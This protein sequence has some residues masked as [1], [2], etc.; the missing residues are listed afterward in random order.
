MYRIFFYVVCFTSLNAFSQDSILVIKDSIPSKILHQTTS[1]QDFFKKVRFAYYAE[2]HQFLDNRE[3]KYG[4]APSQTMLGGRLNAMV[5]A[6]IDSTMGLMAGINYLYEYGDR[7]DGNIP[8]VNLFYYF[9]IPKFTAV[10][11]SFPRRGLLNYPL[12]ILTDS[13]DNYR[14]NID[15]GYFEVRGKWGFQNLWVDWTGRQRS[16]V[17]ESFLAGFSGRV[18]MLKESL[19][20][21]DHYFAMYHNANTSLLDNPV[22]DNGGYSIML[23]TDLTKFTPL[24]LFSFR[25]GILGSYD[26]RRE[27]TDKISFQNGG[28]AQLNIHYKWVGI[29]AS[30]YL[31]D[32]LITYYGDKMYGSGNYARINVVGMPFATF[33]N[34][35]VDARVVWGVQFV[36][37]RFQNDQMLTLVV[38]VGELYKTYHN[39]FIR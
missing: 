26:R 11:G 32:K 39:P 1:G 9:Q 38:H 12:A 19:F 22:E 13:L 2:F 15:G 33:P 17:R 21:L 36:N 7:I 34:K 25:A 8:Q 6:K 27:L 29:E 23:G 3:Y 5:G 14:P 35:Y 10:L 20:Y 18:N 4:Y 31:G 28:F 24:S 37:G 30:Y 16:N